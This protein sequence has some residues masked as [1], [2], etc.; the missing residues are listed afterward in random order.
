MQV[1]AVADTCTSV[2]EDELLPRKDSSMPNVK[3]RLAFALD[4]MFIALS[5]CYT[6]ISYCTTDVLS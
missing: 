5:H 6:A 4:G 1:Q 3:K 2:L